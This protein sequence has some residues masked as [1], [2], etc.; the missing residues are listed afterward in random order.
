MNRNIFCVWLA[1]AAM[2]FAA[3]S[4]GGCGGSSSDGGGSADDDV[5]MSD[6]WNDDK[7]MKNTRKSPTA[8]TS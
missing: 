5:T 3:V 6:I 8:R 4:F 7:A 1:V 2:V